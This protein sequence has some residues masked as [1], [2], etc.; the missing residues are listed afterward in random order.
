MKL[1]I[2]NFQLNPFNGK[3]VLVTITV[4][5]NHGVKQLEIP[6][7]PSTMFKGEL[8]IGQELV[9]VPKDLINLIVDIENQQLKI[10]N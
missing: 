1:V 6:S 8:E 10:K 9:L 3:P 7:I 2:T 5:S 4:F